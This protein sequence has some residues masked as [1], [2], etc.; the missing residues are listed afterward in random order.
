MDTSG[1]CE[2]MVHVRSRK[3]GKTQLVH[4]SGGIDT[5]G[6]GKEIDGNDACGSRGGSNGECTQQGKS[7]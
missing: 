3:R 7:V 5:A 1:N 2:D 6:G 4:I